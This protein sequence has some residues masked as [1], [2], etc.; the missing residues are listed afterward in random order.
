[1]GHVLSSMSHFLRRQLAEP[2][3]VRWGRRSKFTDLADP[4][5]PNDT[6]RGVTELHCHPAPDE[7]Y[8]DHG[9]A[10]SRSV[11]THKYR[12]GAELWMSGNQD[13]AVAA[14]LD[15]IE[16]VCGLHLDGRAHG[17]LIE[18]YTSLDL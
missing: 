7:S 2:A 13:L 10:P 8:L 5:C 14:I 9:S 11:K 18:G 6:E 12:L 4:G 3:A 16:I 1:M 15:A 17:K